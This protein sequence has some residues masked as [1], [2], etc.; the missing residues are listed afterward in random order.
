MKNIFLLLVS[1]L[2]FSCNHS[3]TQQANA[4]KVNPSAISI[5]GGNKVIF[6]DDYYTAYIKAIKDGYK[7]QDSLYKNI[8]QY[9]IV[10]NYFSSSEYSSLVEYHFHSVT[11]TTKIQTMIAAIKAKEDKIEKLLLPA[12]M[13][14]NKCLKNDS[15]TIYIQPFEGGNAESIMKKMN[16]IMAVTAGSKQIMLTIDPEVDSWSD[17]IAA[18]L[19]HEYHHA[20]WTKTNFKK[21]TNKWDMLSYLVFEGRA[22]SYAHFIYPMTKVPAWDTTLNDKE[23]ADLW[24]KIKPQLQ[25]TDMNFQRE[26]MFGGRDSYP[27]WGGYCLGYAIVQSAL[28]N[29]PKLTPEEWTNMSP[30][31]ILEMSD[32]K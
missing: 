29:N 11:D 1:A 25:S 9:P 20:Y 32:Y 12:L 4:Y 5:G 27:I 17:R 18:T 28:K 13:S 7:N 2:L 24:A 22:D 23:K 3:A 15:M 10:N 21:V 14:C 6:L 19:A 26:V 30:E 16:G 8:V 31:K